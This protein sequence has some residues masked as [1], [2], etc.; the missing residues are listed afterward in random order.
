MPDPACPVHNSV[1]LLH[2]SLLRLL[3]G[4]NRLVSLPG[5]VPYLTFAYSALYEVLL[6]GSEFRLSEVFR[7]WSLEFNRVKGLGFGL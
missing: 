7:V 2:A 3:L 4:R 5:A 6:G 1:G